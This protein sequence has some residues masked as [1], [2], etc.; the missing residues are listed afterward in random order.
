MSDLMLSPAEMAQLEQRRQQLLSQYAL[1]R[2]QNQYGI[3]L[4]EQQFGQNQRD[5]GLRFEALRERLNS[6]LAR[7]GILSSGIA[8]QDGMDL[9]E[10]SQR[11]F[12][13]ALAAYQAQQ[14]QFQ[15]AD[16]GLESQLQQGL[17]GI[18]LD[19][20]SAEAALAEQLRQVQQGNGISAQ[21]TQPAP[22]QPVY[23]PSAPAPQAPA[24]PRMRQSANAGIRNPRTSFAQMKTQAPRRPTMGTSRAY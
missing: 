6:N 2:A 4:A 22:P 16:A 7:R 10:D 24:A 19:R 8:A 11:Q 12:G 1:G 13:D 23:V 18:E 3:G 5:L 15:I 14:G 20:A 17:Q 21:A 9:N